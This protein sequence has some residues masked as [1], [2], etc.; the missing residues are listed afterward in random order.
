MGIVQEPLLALRTNTALLVLAALGL[1]LSS[2]ILKLL[3]LNCGYPKRCVE[4]VRY[5]LFI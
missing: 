3:Y 4:Q 2:P 5:Y 1:A